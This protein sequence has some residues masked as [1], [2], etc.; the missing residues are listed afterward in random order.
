[1]LQA[2]GGRIALFGVEK[3]VWTLQYSRSNAPV[4]SCQ[5]GDKHLDIYYQLYEKA[6]K[7]TETF[8]QKA[9]MPDIAIRRR[10]G[11]YLFILDPKHGRTY[12]RPRV[13]GVLDR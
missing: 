11:A 13:K 5:I 2:N 3:G 1:K 7:K 4:A 12:S 9:D 8:E 6:R 10:D